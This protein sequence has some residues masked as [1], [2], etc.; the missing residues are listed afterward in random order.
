VARGFRM[1]LNRLPRVTT[2]NHA[3]QPGRQ[4]PADPIGIPGTILM[5]SILRSTL[6]ALAFTSTVWLATTPA[7]ADD[8]DTCGKASGDEAIAACARA[9]NSGLYSGRQLA[10]LFHSRCFEWNKK[11]ESDKAIADCNQAIRLE[12]N[13]TNA[14]FNR[15]YAYKA[16]GRYDRAIEDYDQAIRLNPNHADAINNRGNT[17]NSKGQYDRAIEDYNQAIRLNPNYATAFYNRG[18][19]WARKNDLQRALADFKKFSE[20]SPSDPDGPKA[21]ERVTKAL[22]G[23]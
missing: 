12:P 5:T 4:A 18:A 23:R 15:G 17:Y 2:K 13:D 19:S 21:V 1:R 20:L 6:A 11:Q 9:I 8:V 10:D 16:K 3:F 7:A 14:F 22:S